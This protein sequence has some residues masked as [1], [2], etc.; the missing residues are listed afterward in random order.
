M[1]LLYIQV[2]SV[3]FSVEIKQ[4]ILLEENTLDFLKQ[5]RRRPVRSAILAPNRKWLTSEIP[6]DF[7]AVGEYLM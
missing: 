1:N 6:Y 7:G 5:L 2:I 4:D 3:L